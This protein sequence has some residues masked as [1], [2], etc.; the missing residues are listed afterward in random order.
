MDIVSHFL[1]GWLIGEA[2][3]AS[4]RDTAIIAF[5]GFL[6]DLFQIPIYIYVGK[7]NRRRFHYPHHK[8]WVGA[9]KAHPYL[10]N[11]WEI[12]HS[13]V[14]MLLIVALALALNLPYLAIVAY[15]SH[16]FID[17]FTHTGEWSV[18][19]FYPVKA[20]FEG[21]T[22]AWSWSVKWMV[23]SWLTLITLILIL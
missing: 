20:K 11:L 16:I 3:N 10:M 21:F 13:A 22:D 17:L 19:P 9:R 15:A 5:F 2:A 12:P 1:I 4:L 18:M 23:A 8:D 7:R 6:P 14:F